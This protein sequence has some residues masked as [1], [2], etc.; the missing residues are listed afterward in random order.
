[1]PEDINIMWALGVGAIALVLG[2]AGGVW[3]GM[4]GTS[5]RVG[6]LVES[7]KQ[8]REETREWLKSLQTEVYQ[9][10]TDIAVIDERTR[11]G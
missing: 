4:R 1:M 2:P 5:Q 3:V 9:N 6:S 11:S 7:I 8:D 10:K